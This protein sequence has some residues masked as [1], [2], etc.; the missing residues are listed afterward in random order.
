LCTLSGGVVNHAT[1]MV[2]WSAARHRRGGDRTRRRDVCSSNQADRPACRLFGRPWEQSGRLFM[3]A[4]PACRMRS[5]RD[6]SARAFANPKYKKG[7]LESG[8]CWCRWGSDA[9]VAASR[10]IRV[11]FNTATPSEFVCRFQSDRLMRPGWPKELTGRA[12][13]KSWPEELAQ[14][15]GP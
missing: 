6:R 4:R 1:R 7:T 14:V 11:N 9:R 3:H 10:K 5:S 8:A 12:G 15:N 13:P 2:K